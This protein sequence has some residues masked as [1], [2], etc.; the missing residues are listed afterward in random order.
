MMK[1]ILAAILACAVMHAVP[2]SAAL[3]F[4]LSGPAI[5]NQPSGDLPLD[6]GMNFQVNSAVRVDSLGAF[7]NGGPITVQLFDANSPATALATATVNGPGGGYAFA[8]LSSPLV[9][10][11]GIYQINTLYPASNPN[12]NPFE[13]YSG[14]KPVVIFDSF[15]GALTFLGDYYNLNGNGSFATTLDT[16]SPNGYGA[17]TLSVSAVPEPST[18]AMMIFGFLGVGYLTCRRRN[19]AIA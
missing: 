2:A 12:Y 5:G 16:L 10:G 14:P 13:P 17:G 11:P 7:T 19:H 18:W 3:V 9:L 4:D 1:S 15:G 8:T 6:L